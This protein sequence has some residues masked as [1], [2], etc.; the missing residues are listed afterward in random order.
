MPASFECSAQLTEVVNLAVENDRDVACFV[1][2]G[3]VAA[4]KVNNAEAAHPERRGWSDEQ[5]VLVRAA[6]PK[7][8]HHPARNGFGQVSALNSDDA[9]DSAHGVT[10]S[11]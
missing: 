6:M 5:P 11:C 3:L 8:L 10:W 9:A 7:R 2:Y 1:E 4:G